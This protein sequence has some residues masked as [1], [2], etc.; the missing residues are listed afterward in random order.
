MTRPSY[1]PVDMQ[2]ARNH[3]EASGEVVGRGPKH[4]DATH[5]PSPPPCTVGDRVD[6][7]LND[8]RI[9]RTRVDRSPY[10]GGVWLAGVRGH[11]RV[12][13]VR[14]PGGWASVSG[15]EYTVDTHEVR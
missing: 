3:K 6:V 7:L 14:V 8:G 13:R 10:C 5:I 11:V 4:F 1:N 15:V 9:L 2:R 12:T